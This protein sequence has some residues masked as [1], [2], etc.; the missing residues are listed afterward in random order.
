MNDMCICQPVELYD[1]DENDPKFYEIVELADEYTGGEA[2]DFKWMV[3][4][5]DSIN[6][7]TSLAIIYDSSKNA[8]VIKSMFSK[9]YVKSTG[10]DNNE[11][12]HLYPDSCNRH[13]CLCDTSLG[14]AVD[15][16]F[17]YINELQKKMQ[18]S[19]EIYNF[20]INNVIPALYPVMLYNT[21][22]S[23]STKPLNAFTSFVN[24]YNDSVEE[25]V[26]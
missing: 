6:E 16:S 9:G 1:I 13:I 4:P 12:W 19:S 25:Y 21:S 14:M 18:E 22:C 5:G 11:Y 15:I 8:T 26:D 17:G 24:A 20:L 7:N 2:I 23:A 10:P 3:K